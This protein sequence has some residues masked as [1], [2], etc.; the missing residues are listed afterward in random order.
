ME[1]ICCTETLLH[2]VIKEFMLNGFRFTVEFRIIEETTSMAWGL[3]PNNYQNA[4]SYFI[5]FTF[6]NSKDSIKN[7]SVEGKALCV[8]LVIAQNIPIEVA[9]IGKIAFFTGN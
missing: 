1:M 4:L 2:T 6:G 7:F 5:P 9:K 3:F 8:F